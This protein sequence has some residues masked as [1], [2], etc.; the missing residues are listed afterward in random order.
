MGHFD[1]AKKLVLDCKDTLEEIKSTYEESLNERNIKP[2]LL[3]RIKNFMENLR[4]ALDFTAHGL[5]DKYGDQTKAGYNIYFPYAWECLDLK[6]FNAK[7]LIEKCIPGLSSSRPDIASKIESYQHFSDPNNA[8]LPKFMDL[9]K[10]NKHQNLTPQ[11]RKEVKELRISSGNVGMKLSGGASI[12]ISGNAQIRMGNAI[13]R[14]NQTISP[15]SPAQIFGPA[16]QEVITWV[17]FH[18]TDNKE[19]VIPLLTNAFNGIEKIV[20]ELSAV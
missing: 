17:S 9:N 19:P 5:F 14:G 7:K 1:D 11:T 8:W 12:K 2:K 20:N 15:E 3:I 16:K 6:G 10:A 18:F 13:I 4:S